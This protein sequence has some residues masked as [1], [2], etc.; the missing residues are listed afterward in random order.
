MR[1]YWSRYKEEPEPKEAV[2]YT[3]RPRGRWGLKDC[4]GSKAISLRET[5]A[6]I[7]VR[8]MGPFEEVEGT[9]AAI[10]EGTRKG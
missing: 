2:N 5:Q 8:R 1:E 6:S 9:G 10:P 4:K 3:L 7:K